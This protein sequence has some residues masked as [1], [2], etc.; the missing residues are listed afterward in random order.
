MY[1]PNVNRRQSLRLTAPF[2]D[3]MPPE[4]GNF[5]SGAMYEGKLKSNPEHIVP[6]FSCLKFVDVAIGEEKMQNTSWIVGQSFSR[7][8]SSADVWM[9]VE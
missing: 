8:T 3:R 2:A 6:G 7:S 4:V 5:V 1:A 9:R